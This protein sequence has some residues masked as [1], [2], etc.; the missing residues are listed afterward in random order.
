MKKL[1]LLLSLCFSFNYA[2]I[3]SPQP[4]P[5]AKIEQSVGLTQVTVEYSRPAMRGRTIMGGLVPYGELWRAG[6]N[7]N[8][9]IAF[10]DNVVVGGKDLEAGT[11]AL[12]IRPGISMW[13]IFFYTK[14]EN[15]GLPDP[16]ETE[17][18][19][20]VLEV[21]TKTLAEPL[22][23]FTLS[24]DHLDSNGA[25]INIAWEN[26]QVS[27]PLKVP[28]DTKTMASI[29]STLKGSPKAGDLYS[30]AVY[31]RETQRDLEI[32]KKW[33]AKAIDMDPGKYWMYRQQSLILADL[34]DKE[35]AIESAKMSL[36]LAE[37][38]GNQD[39][40]RLNSNSIAEWSK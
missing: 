19:A 7:K 28:T 5:A 23:S 2:Q 27:V 26:T 3:Q 37:E 4:S 38:A 29:E 6:A 10:S 30:A 24:I 14:T 35:G 12:F 31:Y 11:Y 32:A 21:Q 15:W 20:A 39:Y 18:I 25:T 33:M 1:V 16:W 22:E 40:V 9:T 36:K 8:T 34:N 13:E 17:A